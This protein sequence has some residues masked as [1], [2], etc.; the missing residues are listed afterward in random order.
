MQNTRHPP[1]TQLT[2]SFRSCT[3]W[4]F[5]DSLPALAAPDP[6][7]YLSSSG[8]L[9]HPLLPLSDPTRSFPLSLLTHSVVLHSPALWPVILLRATRYFLVP[10][11]HPRFLK[12][13]LHSLVSRCLFHFLPLVKLL[14]LVSL[15]TVL[16]TVTGDPP[17]AQVGTSS[18]LLWLL[19][20]LYTV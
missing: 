5:A 7:F 10:L 15:D 12:G 3:F 16:A 17:T 8:I 9:C 18:Y 19:D 1:A 11:F 4:Y 6:W 13:T 14:P 2:R 20:A